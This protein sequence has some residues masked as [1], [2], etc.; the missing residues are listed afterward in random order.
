MAFTNIYEL[1]TIYDNRDS[2]YHKAKVLISKDKK[3]FSVITQKS[4]K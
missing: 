3:R 2:F 4:Q 1:E